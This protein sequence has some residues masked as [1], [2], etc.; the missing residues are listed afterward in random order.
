MNNIKDYI[1]NYY[2]DKISQKRSID[3]ITN[4]SNQKNIVNYNQGIG[5]VVTL[6][7]LLFKDQNTRS[8][9]NIFSPSK[10]FSD[11]LYFNKFKDSN[12]INSDS[13]FRVELLEFYNLGSGHLIQ[14]MR[15]FF[16]LPILAKPQSYLNTNKSKIKNKV[17]IHL[18]TGQSAYLLN[19]H[20]KPRQIY[21]DNIKVINSFI[22]DH[23]Q[24]SFVEFGG[25]SVGLE[26]C[27]NFCGKSITESIEELS[28]CEYFIGLNSGFM[29]LAA[30]FDI[31]SIIIINIPIKASD[32]VLPVLKDIQM[33]D[34]NWLYPQNVHLHQDS[35]SDLVPKFSYDSL[36]K[37]INGEVYPFWKEDYLDLI[38]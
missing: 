31:N 7:N 37:A 19:I 35:H 14:K 1:I 11:I 26:N 25:E 32:V 28:T 30:C 33:S 27:N 2:F 8:D 12:H 38:S 36:K 23:P 3:Q 29:N 17:G 10:H 18:S 13:F 4:D 16:G 6:S 22:K 5:D 34:M 20:S 21:S 15:R 24:Y 9:L